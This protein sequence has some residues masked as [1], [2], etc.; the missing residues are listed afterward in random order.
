MVT[1]KVEWALYKTSRKFGLVHDISRQ[2]ECSD[3]KRL[4][5]GGQDR[6][7]L[8]GNTEFLLY[9][10]GEMLYNVQCP[11]IEASRDLTT[12]D[13]RCYKYLPVITERPPTKRFLI[14]GSRLLSNISE[15]EPYKT[16]DRVPRGY[17]TTKGYWL[18]ACPQ[19]KM[20]S[21]PTE[22]QIEILTTP[23]TYENEAKGGAY[24]DRDLAEWARAFAWDARRTIT[25]THEE[26]IFSVHGICQSIQR[27][28]FS[29][30]IHELS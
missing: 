6:P 14:P 18:V 5:G 30:T 8:Q 23:D 2:A 1:L 7:E 12:N 10:K 28:I 27:R 11:Q 15:T 26:R 25:Q 9:A 21:P 13:D 29:R 24:M 19:P 4:T 22:L 20:L 16:A 3:L 17:L